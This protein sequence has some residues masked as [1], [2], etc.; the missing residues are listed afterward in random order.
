MNNF[1]PNMLK[2][3]ENCPKKFHYKYNERISIPQNPAFFEKGK[4]IHALANFYLR[5]DEISKLETALSAD[6]KILWEKLKSNEFF[7][8]KCLHSEY[9]ITAKIQNHWIFGRL[10]ALMKEGDDYF[11]LDYKTGQIPRNPQDDFQTMVY[12]LCADK[13]IQKY[14][15]LKFVYIDLKNDE[16]HIIEFTPEKKSQFELSIDKLCSEI[17]AIK[18]FENKQN[19]LHCKF[20]EYNK[21]CIT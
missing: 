9:S 18:D 14:N 20:C 21:I 8:K 6:E 17:V 5:G 7:T 13:I 19:H 12:L 1:S 16:N 11:I 2:T 10:D 4:K 15:S 3:F